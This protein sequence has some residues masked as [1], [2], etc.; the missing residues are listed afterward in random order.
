[1]SV[2]ESSGDGVKLVGLRVVDEHPAENSDQQ[3]EKNT[4]RAR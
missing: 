2:V 4:S 3:M 1:M